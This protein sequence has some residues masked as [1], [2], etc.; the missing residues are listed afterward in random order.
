VL[1]YAIVK[2]ESFGWGS[3]RTLGLGAAAIAL[4]VAFVFIERRSKSP[5]IRLGVFRIRSLTIANLV[6][7]AVGG[8]L[9]AN[10]FF[11]SLYVQQ[12]LGYT[13]IDAG[14]AFLPVTVGIGLGAGLA[15]QLIKR[16]D[17]RHIA[18]GGMVL[19]AA[20][21]FILSLVPVDGAYLPDLLPGLL[22]MAVGMG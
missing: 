3:A 14:L 8:G 5:L 21:L 20:G 22:P 19:A 6:L 4:L 9:F 10:F 11:A 13:P 2:A 18:V 17:V 15:Q 7:L 16:F 12:I 1:V